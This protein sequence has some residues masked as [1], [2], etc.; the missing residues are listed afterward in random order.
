MSFPMRDYIYT[1]PYPF[2]KLGHERKMARATL[3][4]GG[5]YYSPM[6]IDY[7]LYRYLKKKNI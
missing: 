6:S 5:V 7:T 4:Y 3:K 1:P 2:I